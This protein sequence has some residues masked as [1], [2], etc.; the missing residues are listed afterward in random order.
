MSSGK[1]VF[2]SVAV[3]VASNVV[4]HVAQKSIPTGVHPLLT[5]AVTYAAAL[6]ATLLL[7]LVWPGGPPKLSGLAQLNWATLGVAISAVGIEIGFLLA[8]RAGWNI[9]VGSLIVSVVVALLLVPTGALLFHEQLS[10]ANIAGIVL[11]LVGLALVM[12]K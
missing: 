12:L 2:L 7:W 3:I 6:V 9:N 1:I 5:V 8:Y 4:Y 11:S 10:A